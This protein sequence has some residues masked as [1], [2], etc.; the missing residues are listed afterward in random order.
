M[1][2]S[3]QF[4]RPELALVAV[5]ALW[6]ASFILLSISLKGLSPAL[7]MTLRF[8]GGAILMACLLRSSLLKLRKTDWIAG[9]STGCFIFLGYFLQTVGLQTITSSIS[10]FLTAL[11]VPFVPLFQFVLFRKKPSLIVTGGI[12]FA[13]IGMMLILDPTNLSLNGSIGEWLTIASAGA[14]A[15]E[16]IVLGHFANECDPRAFCFT[17][18]VTVATLSGLYCLGFEEIRFAPTLSTCLCMLVLIGMI[19]FNQVAMCWAQ[20]FVSPSRAVL[21]YTLEPVFA[22][23]IGYLVGEPFS[24]GAVCGAV[25]VVLSILISSWLPGYLAN[26]GRMSKETA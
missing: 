26:R 25:M 3:E 23:I 5:T 15:M 6:G 14:C 1:S 21:I 16:I 4:V 18:L 11:Y 9:A 2:S 12:I 24:T 13:F 8:A 19:A 20:K 17:Q 7:L 10:A 22:G